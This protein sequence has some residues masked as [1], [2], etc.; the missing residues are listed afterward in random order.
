M[1]RTKLQ[2]L[3]T[4]RWQAIGTLTRCFKGIVSVYENVGR[5]EL[6]SIYADSLSSAVYIIKGYY[7]DLIAAEKDRLKELKRISP[8]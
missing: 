7:D 1:A 5:H 6:S 4:A 8:T 3:N 2:E